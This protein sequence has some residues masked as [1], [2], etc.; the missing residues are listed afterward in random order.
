M[1]TIKKINRTSVTTSIDKDIYKKI[2]LLAIENDKNA[3]ELI[4]EGMEYII[5]KYKK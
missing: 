4:E 1:N 2:K 3:N 5:L